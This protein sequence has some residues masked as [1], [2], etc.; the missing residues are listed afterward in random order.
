MMPPPYLRYAA[1]LSV[2]HAAAMLDTRAADERCAIVYA[3]AATADIVVFP[4]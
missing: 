2:R 1:T 3:A 4:R